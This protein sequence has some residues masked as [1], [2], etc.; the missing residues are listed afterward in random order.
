[1]TMVMMPMAVVVMA[2]TNAEPDV[3]RSDMRADD[4]GIGRGRAQHGDGEQRGDQQLH[5]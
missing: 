4:V 3:D 2:V 1:M 5:G